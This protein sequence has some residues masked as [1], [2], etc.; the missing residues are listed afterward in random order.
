MDYFLM[1][2]LV[3]LDAIHNTMR[4]LDAIAISIVFILFIVS[5]AAICSNYNEE[6]IKTLKK[7]LNRAIIFTSITWFLSIA[8]PTTKEVAVIYVIPK[9][10]N[11][12]QVQELGKNSLDA[13]VNLSKEWIEEL[14]PD[15]KE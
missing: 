4:I 15:K 10:V 11:N 1:Y 5:L 2:L 12:E 7:S 13:L 14:K 9:I 3:K 6:Y 8:I